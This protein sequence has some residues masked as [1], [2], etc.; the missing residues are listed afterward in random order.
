MNSIIE[1]LDN[2]YY[3]YR[4]AFG[5][6]E[7]TDE[8]A[9][10]GNHLDFKYRGYDARLGRF[11]SVDPLSRKYPELSPFQFASLSPIWMRELEGLEGEPSQNITNDKGDIVGK[12]E[13]K[14]T[15]CIPLR[16]VQD[17]KELLTPKPLVTPSQGTISP[18]PSNLEK[19]L[20]VAVAPETENM[21]KYDNVFRSVSVGIAGSMIAVGAIETAPSVMP[22]L[23][24]KILETYEVSK[25]IVQT[26]S[27]A[28]IT[29]NTVKIGI[30][31]AYGELSVRNE[32]SPDARSVLP[33]DIKLYSQGYTLLRKAII[34]MMQQQSQTNPAPKKK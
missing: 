20:D 12:T 6:Q 26:V 28:Y 13:P 34:E 29:N 8:I 21:V 18:S 27:Y 4:F 19:F 23:A 33:A 15:T 11:W 16:P 1:I 31:I 5:G 10:E 17:I 7:K 30:G 25:S 2:S 3:P 22:A 9:G 14:S 32:F 24:P